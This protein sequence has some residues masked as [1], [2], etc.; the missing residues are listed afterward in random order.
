ME[1]FV[2]KAKASGT[3]ALSF[4]IIFPCKQF[5]LAPIALNEIELAMKLGIKQ[6]AVA[7]SRFDKAQ[8]RQLITILDLDS[9][10]WTNR[11]TPT[12]LAVCVFLHRMSASGAR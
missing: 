11:N 10:L 9:I 4:K 7:Y 2:T 12:D 3:I 5:C 8:I 1:A 6:N